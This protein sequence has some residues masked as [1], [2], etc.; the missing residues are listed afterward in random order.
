[1]GE[2]SVKRCGV[3]PASGVYQTQ[4]AGEMPGTCQ[5]RARKMSGTPCAHRVCFSPCTRGRSPTCCIGNSV[6]DTVAPTMSKEPERGDTSSADLPVS[7]HTAHSD[8][9]LCRAHVVWNLRLWGRDSLRDAA[10]QETMGETGWGTLSSVGTPELRSKRK[11][12]DEQHLAMLQRQG[13]LRRH[14]N[15]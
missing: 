1:M 9:V 2:P 15:D 13:V 11:R 7:E 6:L 14:T 4:G 5:L 10:I 3:T 12:V 8:W